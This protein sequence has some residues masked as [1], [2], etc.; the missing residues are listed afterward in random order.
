MTQEDL[1]TLK[2]FSI[3]ADK[4]QEAVVRYISGKTTIKYKVDQPIIVEGGTDETIQA[5]LIAN[6]R[7]FMGDNKAEFNK[8]VN[9]L[10]KHHGDEKTKVSRL[11][12]YK[13]AW[14]KTFGLNPTFRI[15]SEEDNFT[16]EK[17]FDIF[18]N[19]SHLHA[20]SFDE[21]ANL[22]ASWIYPIAIL[23]LEAY[24]I[25]IRSLTQMLKLEFID[26]ILTEE[27]A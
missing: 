7:L 16:N 20:T 4:L 3:S 23:Q 27:K 1:K 9:I 6:A 2:I 14:K 8:V 24:I 5:G 26:A 17:V 11:R 18:A 10:L 15:G 21:H 13:K 25:S 19:G 22:Q 12:N